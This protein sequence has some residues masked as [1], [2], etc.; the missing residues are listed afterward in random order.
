MSVIGFTGKEIDVFMGRLA[1]YL[2]VSNRIAYGLTYKNEPIDFYSDMGDEI[3]PTGGRTTKEVYGD[4]RHLD[5][6]LCSNGGTVFMAEGWGDFWK[7]CKE[8]VADAAIE[9]S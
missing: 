6:N 9:R 1:G 4:L 3:K 8:A 2:A 5:Y 7:A